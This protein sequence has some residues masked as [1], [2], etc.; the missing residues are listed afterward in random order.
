MVSALLCKVAS[1]SPQGEHGESHA[2]ETSRSA[3]F[4]GSCQLAEQSGRSSKLFRAGGMQQSANAAF[5]KDE[6]HE[7]KPI[8]CIR[9]QGPCD[10]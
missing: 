8:C 5:L 7:L 6:S 3:G 1:E 9:K 2:S 4:S 10:D